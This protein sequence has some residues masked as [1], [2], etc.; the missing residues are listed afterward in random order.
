MM[1]EVIQ[2]GYGDIIPKPNDPDDSIAWWLYR[3]SKALGYVV[4]I[5]NLKMPDHLTFTYNTEWS[6]RILNE[7]AINT[8]DNRHGLTYIT[9]ARNRQ[10]AIFS[11][12]H[13][14]LTG[15]YLDYAVPVR[16]AHD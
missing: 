12:Y 1:V 8:C 9:V 16:E 3:I 11:A 4:T 6:N 7:Y 2:P 14:Y 15:A 10:D 5:D 13:E